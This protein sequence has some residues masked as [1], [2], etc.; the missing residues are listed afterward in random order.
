MA[1]ETALRTV[2]TLLFISAIFFIILIPGNT[3]L[4]TTLAVFIA[5]LGFSILIY[6]TKDPKLRNALFGIPRKNLLKSIIWGVIF[7]VGFFVIAQL[8][9]LSIGLPRLFGS[10][11]DTVRSITV[12]YF[13]P[14]LESVFFQSVVYAFLISRGISRTGALLGHAAIFATAHTAAYVIG[15]YNYPSFVEGFSAIQ[16]NIGAFASV[17]IFAII[18]ML[19][20]RQP[21]I[22]NLAF[23]IVFHFIVNLTI[24]VILSTVF[25]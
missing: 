25:I 3:D 4:L 1:N 9:G 17:F 16:A 21:K 15:F 24:T 13:A 19:F 18:G 20:M 7:G 6:R 11:S 2:I 12:L 22:N 5:M 14:V 10:I 23:I 8:T